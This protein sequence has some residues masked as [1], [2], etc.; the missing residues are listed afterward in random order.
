MILFIKP[1]NYNNILA[2]FNE[3]MPRLERILFTDKESD[4]YNFITECKLSDDDKIFYDGTIFTQKGIELRNKL[5]QYN[6]CIYKG[7]TAAAI[8]N[9]IAAQAE[10][11]AQNMQYSINMKQCR[12]ATRFMSLLE[13]YNPTNPNSDTTAAELMATAAK[14]IRKQFIML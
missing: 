2:L 14:Y 5:Q 8:R 10:W 7:K 1:T 6:C 4:I 9:L 11:I 3:M 12:H 13:D